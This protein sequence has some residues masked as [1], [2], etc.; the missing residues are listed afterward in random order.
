MKAAIKFGF[1]FLSTL[2][3]TFANAQ[4]LQLFEDICVAD[5]NIYIHNFDVTTVYPSV[6][7]GSFFRF[8]FGN[9]STDAVYTIQGGASLSERATLDQ[10]VQAVFASLAVGKTI[11]LCISRSTNPSSVI[12]VRY[13]QDNP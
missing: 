9:S 7:G 4:G 2:S 8:Y 3:A 13:D 11:D 10:M 6:S 5:N 12:A 1:F